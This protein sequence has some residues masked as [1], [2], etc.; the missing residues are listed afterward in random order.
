MSQEP[1][2]PQPHPSGRPRVDRLSLKRHEPDPVEIYRHVFGK[3]P[4]VDPYTGAFVVPTDF[5]QR[6]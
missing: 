4:V 2:P 3:E 5:D 6:R 1:Q